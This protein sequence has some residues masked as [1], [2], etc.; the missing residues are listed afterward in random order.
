VTLC[1]FAPCLNATRIP[2]GIGLTQILFNRYKSSTREAH[3]ADP[4][5]DPNI[6]P[7]TPY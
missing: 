3:T 2:S 1:I 4:L 5:A 7:F 6:L